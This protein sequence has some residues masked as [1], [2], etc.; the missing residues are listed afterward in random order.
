M[1]WPGLDSHGPARVRFCLGKTSGVSS[2]GPRLMAY[3][4]DQKT[5]DG[6]ILRVLPN[7]GPKHAGNGGSRARA[8]LICEF[9]RCVGHASGSALKYKNIDFG[10]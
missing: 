4:C 3:G 5:I 2:G 1:D 10:G 6:L 7:K 9:E 8:V